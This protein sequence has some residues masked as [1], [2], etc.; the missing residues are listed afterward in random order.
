MKKL[1]E[2]YHNLGGVCGWLLRCVFC[3]IAKLAIHI[4]NVI[5]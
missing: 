2:K 5:T 3:P 1:D 4:I